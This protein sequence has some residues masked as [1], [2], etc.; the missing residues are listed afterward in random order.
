[1]YGIDA[2]A[3]QA[4]VDAGGKTIAVMPCGANIIHP[5]YQG[6]LYH[7]ILENNGLIV[8][9]F[10]KDFPPAVWTY[11]KR[12]RIVA[13]LSKAVLVV[14]AGERSGSL[15]TANFA[16]KYK[17]KIFVLPGPLTSNVYKGICQLIK[18]GAEVITEANDI[19]KFFNTKIIPTASQTKD[20]NSKG[21]SF[22]GIECRIIEELKKEPKEIDAL[23]MLLKTTYVETSKVVSFME[24]KGQIKN[25]NGKYYVC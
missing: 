3:H 1:M 7:K 21:L 8:S 4:T 19:L 11:P 17:R 15:I 2:T 13:G 20:N 22:R 5:E 10:E 6:K 9:E 18:Q 12:N 25:K 23:A 24:I 14:E 16:K